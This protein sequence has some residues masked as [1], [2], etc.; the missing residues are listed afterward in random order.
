[1]PSNFYDIQV[2]GDRLYDLHYLYVN[3]IQLS[4]DIPF[5]TSPVDI[6]D[7]GLI[8]TIT[9]T[10]YLGYVTGGGSGSN[11][12]SF[13]SSYTY[14]T[15]QRLKFVPAPFTVNGVDVLAIFFN[16]YSVSGS[17]T[18]NLMTQT[19]PVLIGTQSSFSFSL[20]VQSTD[21]Y[22]GSDLTSTFRGP[23]NR[24]LYLPT[25]LPISLDPYASAT[26]TLLPFTTG[27]GLKTL[28]VS[29]TSGFTVST[30]TPLVWKVNALVNGTIIAT[31]Q[32][33]LTIL[34]GK[35]YS[36]PE[37]L[38]PS[39]S[40]YIFTPFSYVFSLSN[41]PTT[42]LIY[43][44]SDPIIRNYMTSNYNSTVLTF[45]STTGFTSATSNSLLSVQAIGTDGGVIAELNVYVTA[46]GNIITSVPP[47]TGR[48]SLYKYEPFL[49]TY[50]FVPGVVGLTISPAAS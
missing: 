16:V 34:Q 17:G 44:N 15:P 14:T 13:V 38:P 40:T 20:V 43:Y 30:T 41:S 26:S 2:Q 23:P 19:S 4:I 47:F 37:L 29:S 18:S 8:E 45:A 27:T 31:I 32:T 6:A 11:T 48:I 36:V 49:Y 35:I 5:F 50:G 28:V 46:S 7:F 1:M 42:T 25:T 9:G 24:Q 22:K 12:L 3:N 10:P 33:L 39:L 21:G